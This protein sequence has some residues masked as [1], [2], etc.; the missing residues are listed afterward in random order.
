MTLMCYLACTYCWPATLETGQCL[1]VDDVLMA[2][3]HS[4][5]IC[6]AIHSWNPIGPMLVLC[7]HLR[8]VLHA[9][10]QL[11]HSDSSTLFCV[12]VV[13]V[14]CIDR[15]HHPVCVSYMYMCIYTLGKNTSY[16]I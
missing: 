9:S 14:H 8:A 12:H 1:C 2:C 11:H 10:T 7:T 4:L 16:N 15:Y 13:Y 6:E 3:K 5:S